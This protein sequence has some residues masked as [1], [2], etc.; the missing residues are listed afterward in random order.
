MKMETKGMQETIFAE[1]AVELA[2]IRQKA[3]YEKEIHNSTKKTGKMRRFFS[4]KNPISD[5]PKEFRVQKMQEFNQQIASL[6][7]TFEQRRKTPIAQCVLHG[8][9]DVA[10]THGYA[11]RPSG[12]RRTG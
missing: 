8:Q 7:E 1:A 12:P 9:C 11:C 2:L 6:K 5:R 10:D 3:V 4:K